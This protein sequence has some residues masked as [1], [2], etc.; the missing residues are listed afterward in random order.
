MNASEEIS[1]CPFCLVRIDVAG[2]RCE[3][4]GREIDSDKWAVPRYPDDKP[5][6]QFSPATTYNLEKSLDVDGQFFPPA[7]RENCRGILVTDIK[8]EVDRKS[9]LRIGSDASCTMVIEG[10]GEVLSVVVD[11]NLGVGEPDWW[12]YDFSKEA[13]T[14]VNRKRV[15]R[16]RKLSHEDR[17]IVAGIPLRFECSEKTAFLT[18]VKE[19]EDGPTASVIKV[20]K[21]IATKDNGEKLL[22]AVDFE[23]KQ[24][25]FVAVM[26]P[27]GCGKSSLIQRIA[28]LA[29]KDSGTI[30]V[31][32][33]FVYLPQDVERSLHPSMTLGQEIQSYR[34]IY[35]LTESDDEFKSRKD[36]VLRQLNLAD[37]DSSGDRI[38]GFS[39]GEKR[40][41]G[42]AL[43]LL[44]DPKI[45]LL[46]EPFAGLDPENERKLT[47]ELYKLAKND[48]RTIVCVTHGLSNKE[49]FDRL[50]I[51]GT[52]GMRRA[53]DAAKRLLNLDELLATGNVTKS[54]P[55][56]SQ[57]RIPEVRK[58]VLRRIVLKPLEWK[59]RAVRV[60][61]AMKVDFV[62]WRRALPKFENPA[63]KVWLTGVRRVAFG[64]LSRYWTEN[65]HGNAW[66]KSNLVVCCFW[67]PLIIALGIRL[68]CAY[69]FI[70]GSTD[71][72]A[73]CVALSLF[74]LG[75]INCSRLLVRNRVP[76]RCLERLGGVSVP[77]YL[78]SKFLWVIGF[79]I[80]QTVIFVLLTL[81]LS[82]VSFDLSRW[83][84]ATEKF[85]S[86][87]S[88][89]M[90]CSISIVV[91]IMP[92]FVVSLLGGF[93]GL[94][95]SSIFK[96][97]LKATAWATNFAIFALLFGRCVV[98]IDDICVESIVPIVKGMPCYFPSQWMDEIFGGKAIMA[99]GYWFCCIGL[100]AAYFVLTVVV[101]CFFE[102]KNERAWQG[103]E[104]E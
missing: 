89:D 19:S 46:D 35:R 18:P 51:L 3:K 5:N 77:V 62:A 70:K 26:G 95:M 72:L 37:K 76:G 39:G 101:V 2:D 6:F 9:G 59:D 93:C 81:L 65:I 29:P 83:T 88:A 28:G 45:L 98:K 66:Y 53:Y 69:N 56:R 36:K 104:V 63:I 7:L 74:W 27:S 71:V 82:Q 91:S 4:C 50:L 48:D 94:A 73:F 99:N 57:R 103:R 20:E 87:Q 21:L 78:L 75:D 96:T 15:L 17:V 58:E 23:V 84:E 10:C 16:V 43:A 25:E 44:R 79:C 38:G 12:I 100:L 22:D 49:V 92:M 41:V 30:T 85:V 11:R 64:Y 40:R 14:F 55:P 8:C 68:A 33:R 1:I 67:Q 90:I 34:Q 13:G 42:L 32:D 97:E 54:I 86:W 102:W 60:L 52:G 61:K 80:V 47:D 31:T 24:G